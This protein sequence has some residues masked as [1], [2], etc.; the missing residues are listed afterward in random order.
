VTRAATSATAVWQGL[1][2]GV[3]E[4]PNGYND[5]VAHVDL[6]TRQVDMEH[7]GA[8]FFT[9]YLGGSALAAFYLLRDMP[10]GAD[11]LGPENVLVVAPSVITGAPISGLS[12]FNVTAKS[13]ESGLIGDS[14]CG[15]HFGP[16][17]KYA[18]FDALVIHGKADEP[19]YLWVADGKVEIRPAGHLVDLLTKELQTAV[20]EELGD[21][22]IQV[23]QNGPAG[24][25][26]VRFANLTNNLHHMSGRTGMGAVMG[27]KNLVA[28]AARGKRQYAFADEDKVRELARKGAETFKA[29]PGWQEF[30]A[31][32]TPILVASN[33][34]INNLPTI[35]YR[36]GSFAEAEG[37]ETEAFHSEMTTSRDSCANCVMRCKQQVAADQPWPIDAAY[38]GPEFETI[39]LLGS[40]L[41]I[42]D[43]RAVAK[44]NELCNA[45]GLDSITTGGLVAFAIEC[46]QNGLLGPDDTQGLELRFGDGEVLVELVRRIGERENIGDLLAEGFQ[47]AIATIGPESA[48]HAVHVKG[49]GLPAH[50]PQAKKTMALMYAVNTFGPDHMSCEHDGMLNSCGNDIVALG[51]DHAVPFDEMNDE[52]VRYVVYTQFF[53]SLLDT[54]ELCAFCFSPGGLYGY[55]DIEDIVTAVTG[56]PANLWSL[57]K[58]GE[59]RVNMMNAFNRREGLKPDLDALP[60]RVFEPYTQGPKAGQRLSRTVIKK[61]IRSYYEMMGW[62]TR[63]G[64][65]R[66]GKLRELGLGWV[67][68]LPVSSVEKV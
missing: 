22:R 67:E 68:E 65:P 3:D 41:G 50:M 33:Q 51:I 19:V 52:K 54:L 25:R 35:N 15:G 64:L 49:I 1:L 5:C 9:K 8:E 34:K 29:S 18:G 57:M 36:D 56:F 26:L 38:G 48:R 45:Y 21:K 2:E 66:P 31:N 62:S 16:Q 27:A 46:Y 6:T 40:N 55:R 39:G 23:L 7:P 58:V 53:Y 13:P 20:R 24:R 47:H 43:I 28:V 17:L 61:A 44:A 37:I 4:M 60:E 12:R 30:G 63:T 42:S 14:Q 10:A 59:R 11:A 32:G